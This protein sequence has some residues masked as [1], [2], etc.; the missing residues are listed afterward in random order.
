MKKIIVLAAVCAVAAFGL[1]QVM[2]A[3]A[4]APAKK[5][6][7]AKPGKARPLPFHGEVKAVDATA[8]TFTLGEH[9]Y[10]VTSKTVISKAGTPGVFE[11]VKAGVQ[12]A[13]SYRKGEGDKFEVNTL[14]IGKPEGDKKPK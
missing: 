1:P 7:P 10:T 8:K 14:K 5:A 12:V 3:D 2:A 9:T 11:D 13:G 4:P 6:D